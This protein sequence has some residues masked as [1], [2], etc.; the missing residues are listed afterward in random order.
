[1]IGAGGC[2]AGAALGG[3]GVI[4][5]ANVPNGATL[6]D[7]ITNL[8]TTCRLLVPNAQNGGRGDWA[9]TADGRVVGCSTVRQLVQLA[10]STVLGSAC[11]TSLGMSFVG[12][13]EK[14]PNFQRQVATA[15]A[16]ALAP[17]V[18]QG[19]VAIVSVK[20]ADY[21][22]N[23]DSALGY[24]KWTDLTTGLQDTSAIGP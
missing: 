5:T 17:L 10:L 21:Q 9:F 7:Q 20:L 24:V 18:K 2:P 6:P 14:G 4:S 13:Q 22:S 15:V 3:Y 23:P 19:L 16:N 12:L 8:P 11:V 1:V